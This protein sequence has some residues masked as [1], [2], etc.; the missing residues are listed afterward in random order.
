[1]CKDENVILP[2][3]EEQPEPVHIGDRRI[4]GGPQMIQLSLDGKRLYVTTSLQSAWDRMFYP[5]MVK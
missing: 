3:G 5:D 4:Y 2:D 1:M